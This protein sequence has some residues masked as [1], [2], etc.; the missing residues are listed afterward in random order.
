[1]SKF[2]SFPSVCFLSNL[3]VTFDKVLLFLN[4]LKSDLF[5]QFKLRAKETRLHFDF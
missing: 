1:M 3:S 2:V 5:K 4:T